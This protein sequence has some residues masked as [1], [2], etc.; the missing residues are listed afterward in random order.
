MPFAQANVVSPDW[1]LREAGVQ[2]FAAVVAGPEQAK[3]VAMARSALPLL[4][5]MMKDDPALPVRRAAAWAVTVCIT[6]L[7][8]EAEP[9]DSVLTPDA[10]PPVL[11]VL[12]ASLAAPDLLVT[13]Y[14]CYALAKLCEGYAPLS[15]EA[16]SPLS[17]YFQN[18]LAAVL[19]CAERPEG[20]ARLRGEAFGTLC[21]ALN[22]ASVTE[23]PLLAQLLP[24]VLAKLGATMEAVPATPDALQ[25]QSELQG[26]LCGVL[27]IVT[28]RLAKF[29]GAH[30]ASLLALA[31]HLM[32]AYLRVF[33]CR[34]A[35]VHGEALLAVSALAEAVGPAFVKY[36][37]PDGFAPVLVQ[38]LRNF[39]EYTV[40]QSAVEVVGDLCR[41]LDGEFNRFADEIMVELLKDLASNDLS[42]LVKPAI[43]SVFGDVALALGGS[44]ERFLAHVT[45]MLAGAAQHTVVKA[46]EA[47]QADDLDAAEANNRLRAAIMEAYTGIVQGMKDDTA[48]WEALVK[49]Q[50]PA[51]L[52][53]IATCC[54]DP[55]AM[56]DEGLL[57]AAV[58][59]V[60]D[61][62]EL[63]GVAPLCAARAELQHLL[64]RCLADD[65]DPMVLHAARHTQGVVMANMAPR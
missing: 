60:G 34:S 19:A 5:G 11:A 41:A 51:V 39:A 8:A 44:F 30:K 50:A 47:A 56:D 57:M 9:A 32:G 10:L 62:A 29:E 33:A 42:T 13:S 48:K 17:P 16:Q 25:A 37:G 43:I 53:F 21:D 24:H 4:L 28:H 23:G 7:H 12:L 6:E 61:L 3:V 27:M 45:P 52:D 18:I 20:G 2:A 38:A 26:E 64:Q 46:A 59:L 49:P 22:A 65:A 55:S 14:A 15:S 31:D 54:C 58:G 35:T 40:C 63:P 1:R 36:M